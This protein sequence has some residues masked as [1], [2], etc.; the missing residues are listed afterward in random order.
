MRRIGRVKA[1]T[2]NEMRGG[3]VRCA[4]CGRPAV[5]Q[6]SCC[7]NDHRFVAVCLECDFA[8]NEMALAFF[9]VPGR[10]ALMARYRRRERRGAC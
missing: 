3:K 2:V 10:A 6:W 8:L 5:H 9:R 4:G 1:Y 7:A